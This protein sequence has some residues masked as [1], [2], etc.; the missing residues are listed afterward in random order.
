MT[1]DLSARLASLPP[2]TDPRYGPSARTLLR[3]SAPTE[4]ELTRLV[5]DTD[6]AAQVRFN[7]FYCLQ[8]RAWRRKD[9]AQHRTNTDQYQSVFGTHPM[10]YFMQAEYFAT[11]S[12]DPAN[13][14]AALIFATEAVARLRTVP[15]VLH[16]AAEVIAER[17]ERSTRQDAGA[18]S[19]TGEA[20]D[21]LLLKGERYVREAIALSAGQYPRYHA[22]LARLATLRGAY[23]TAHASIEQAIERED[24][25]GPEYALRIGDY[26]LVR[27]RIQFAQEAERL[28]GRQE[29]STRELSQMRTQILEIMGLL[30]AVIAF[31]TAAANIAANQDAT[32]AAGLLT[33]AGGVTLIVFWGF[34]T[35]L[36]DRWTA[37]RLVALLLGVVLVVAGLVYA[38]LGDS[39]ESP[40]G[41]D[42]VTQDR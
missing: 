7:A 38:N 15:G 27:S 12:A 4:A 2:E 24:S 31:I 5:D 9:F 19:A 14:D 39:R 23:S 3:D 35:L 30:A 1:P 8:A 40:D 42:P 32:A 28:R 18:D 25:A 33:V 10:F 17:Q 34:H 22:T 21:Q 11:L 6:A 16:L 29:E 13:L 26:Q 20:E 37:R 41:A 36:V